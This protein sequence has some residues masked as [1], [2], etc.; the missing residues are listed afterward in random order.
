MA[1]A[2]DTASAEEAAP[3]PMHTMRD[4]PDSLARA[5]VAASRV[6]CG[7][8][9]LGAGGGELLLEVAVGVE[10]LDDRVVHRASSD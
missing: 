1:R 2:R 3:V 4:T 10:P 6:A 5:M 8:G 7:P 9:S